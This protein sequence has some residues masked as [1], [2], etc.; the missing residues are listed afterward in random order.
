MEI[1]KTL[2]L[3]ILWSCLT[4]MFISFTIWIVDGLWGM[5]LS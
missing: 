3:T 4:A 2:G 5:I 1:L